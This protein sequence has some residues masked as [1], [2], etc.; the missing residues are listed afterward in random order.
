[1]IGQKIGEGQF[2]MVLEGTLMTGEQMNG[3]GVI[4]YRRTAWSELGF[5][6]DH[7]GLEL[8]NGIYFLVSNKISNILKRK[9]I[10]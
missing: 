6:L 8:G 1:M 10:L 3:C 4:L 5:G 2:G 7:F 9:Y